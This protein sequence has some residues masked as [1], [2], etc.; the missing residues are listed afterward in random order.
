MGNEKKKGGG[1]GGGGNRVYSSHKEK[2]KKKEKK[3]KFIHKYDVSKPK[4]SELSPLGCTVQYGVRIHT[5]FSFFLSPFCGVFSV[6][7]VRL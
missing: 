4:P 3:R 1:G 6:Y 2:A 5:L 7:T